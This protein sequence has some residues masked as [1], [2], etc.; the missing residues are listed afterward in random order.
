MSAGLT[1]VLRH[2]R[3]LA[4]PPEDADDARRVAAF[5]ARRDEGAFA[6]LVGRHGPMV[7]GVC[8]RLLRNDA[9]ADDAFQ[10]VFL[11]LARKAASL[12]GYRSVAGWL[13][14]VAVRTARKARAARDR[15]RIHE[16]EAAAMTGTCEA[17]RDVDDLRP[18]LDEELA[19]LPEKYRLPLVLCDLQGYTHGQAAVEVGC[20]VG[21]V[22]WRLAR[23]REL[24]RRR[25]LGRGVTLSGAALAGLLAERTAAPVSAALAQ[26]TVG[27]A[28]AFA[29]GTAPKLSAAGA[30]AEEVLKGL[31]LG[32]TRA[33]AL[34][35]LAVTFLALGG[36]LLAYQPRAE[37]PAPADP[38]AEKPRADPQ[39]DPLPAG[40]LMRLGTLR[41]RVG[42][43]VRLLEYSPDG[44]LL[45]V[46][47]R[48]G[49]TLWDAATGKPLR[50][51]EGRADFVRTLAFAPDGKTLALAEGEFPGGKGGSKEP[52][53]RP[54]RLVA[55]PSGKEV[56]RFAPD[57]SGAAA[58]AFSPD[59]KLLAV[60]DA[61]GRILL[62]DPE[63]GSVRGKCAGGG[64]NVVCLAFSA[65][66]HRLAV[67]HYNA[68]R[69][70]EVGAAEKGGDVRL[71]EAARPE[72]PKFRGALAVGFRAE[73]GALVA[74]DEAG[75]CRTW[76]GA[77]KL[78]AQFPDPAGFFDLKAA[79]LSRDG[80]RV[81]PAGNYLLNWPATFDT[82]TGKEVAHGPAGGLLPLCLGFSPDGRT[83]AAV[84]RTGVM[85]FWDARTGKENVQAEGHAGFLWSADLSA[86]GRTAV[87]AA[88]DHSAAVWDATTGRRRHVLDHPYDPYAVALAPDGRSLITGASDGLVRAWDVATGKKLFE[89]KVGG[90]VYCLAFSPDGRLVACG[91]HSLAALI[92]ATTGRVVHRLLRDDRPIYGHVA[93]SADGRR[94][95]IASGY[96]G[97]EETSKLV[98]LWDVATGKHLRRFETPSIV[99]LASLSP[100]GSRLLAD[101]DDASLTWDTATGARLRTTAPAARALP[102][103]LSPDGRTLAALG[104]SGVVL[105]E[106]AG[107]GRR[108]AFPG[109]TGGIVAVQFSRDGR[110]LISGA[111]DTTALIWD[112]TGGRAKR[113]DL[114]PRELAAR[115]EALAADDAGAAFDALWDLVGA[116]GTVG[117]LRQR[118][119]P[120]PEPETARLITAL[121]AESFDEREAATEELASLGEVAEP[122]LAALVGGRPLPEARSRAEGLLKRV[123]EPGDRR[124]TGESLRPVRAVEVLEAVGTPEARELLEALAKGAPGATLTREARESLGRLRR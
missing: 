67:A 54:V 40:A 83:I 30:L 16:R 22:S 70:W 115:W 8:R 124:P 29:A 119:K 84:E 64:E 73:G 109:H 7:L 18:V 95:A 32:K 62:C 2:I 35:A 47:G 52:P 3:R 36:G 37:P 44:K 118:M 104:D 110:R 101:C 108:R 112:V 31:A 97:R 25:L 13:H 75:H 114:S 99:R 50:R 56:R 92:D 21:S 6:E 69:V 76:D 45:A 24:L 68:L 5:A 26:A 59:G 79:A 81:V 23:G 122:A 103:A 43:D 9:D 80:A 117:F 20:P 91:A 77:G 116:P 38:A 66:G 63:S 87:T 46:A 61:G 10:A 53:A 121:D 17:A 74:V 86:D 107:G 28:T 55:V 71:T 12:E 15:R 113:I 58:L 93:F 4:H 94:L 42:E 41:W 123:R 57:S 39:G 96:T 89:A 100:D 34:A 82:A 72:A 19:R 78:L 27:A 60:G 48:G 33:L 106:R 120:V 98:D 51:P 85:R 102:R 11:V 49:L 105:V 1:V 65:D 88:A 14:E 90:C 111:G